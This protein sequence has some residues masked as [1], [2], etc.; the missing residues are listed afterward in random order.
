[1]SAEFVFKSQSRVDMKDSS[2]AQFRRLT[3]CFN[4]RVQGVGFRF[5]TVDVASRHAVTGFVQNE[6]DGTVRVVSEGRESD[7][8]A[9]VAD[10]YRSPLGR[11]IRGEQRDWT[12]A[13]GG[14]TRFGI[15]YC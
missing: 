5:T 11:H 3:V 1:M 12:D 7:L 14:F 2:K 6:W 9:F 13:Q 4:G 10:I 8:D 15:R